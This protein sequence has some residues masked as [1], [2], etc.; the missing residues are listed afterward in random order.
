VVIG[1]TT[2]LGWLI[3]LEQMPQI[4][5]SFVQ[6]VSSSQWTFLLLVNIVLLILGLVLDPVP[7]ILLTAP[8]FIPTAMTFGVDPVHLGVIMTCNVAVGLFTPPV[9]ATLYVAARISG[10]GVLSIARAMGP[11]YIA[12]LAALMLVTYVPAISMTFPEMDR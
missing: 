7:A 5:V 1:S 4:L 9:G 12:A 2:V 10:V 3:T 6:D 11:L 8:L